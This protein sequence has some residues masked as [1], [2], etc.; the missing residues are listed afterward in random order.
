MNK[1]GNDSQL[2]LQ[3]G[4]LAQTFATAKYPN[5]FLERLK[6]IYPNDFSSIEIFLSRSQPTTFW[7]NPLRGDINYTYQTL[8]DQGIEFLAVPGLSNMYYVESE[9]RDSITYHPFA[10][11]GQIYVV[12]PSSI[13]PPLVLSPSPNDLVLDL[14]AAPGSKTI[15]LASM[16]NNQGKISAVDIVRYRYYKLKA[17]LQRNGVTNTVLF[18][19][20]GMSVWDQTCVAIEAKMRSTHCFV[21]NGGPNNL[22]NT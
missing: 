13:I 10:K 19:R 22:R 11:E 15:Q 4:A 9:N 17:N 7:L 3:R 1:K 8:K 16:M 14:T 2:N 6:N 5:L 12:N 21:F 20:D 18:N